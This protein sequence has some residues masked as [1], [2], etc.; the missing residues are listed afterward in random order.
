M[1]SKIATLLRQSI[2]ESYSSKTAISFS[3][4][5]DS[6]VILSILKDQ[7]LGVF[8]L[9]VEGS[10]DLQTSRKV[11]NELGVKLS[12][13]IVDETQILEAYEKVYVLLPMD[14]LSVQILIPVYLVAEAASKAGYKK[15]LFGSGAE[16]LFAGYEKY[17]RAY[18]EG[19]DVESM[20]K[21]EFKTLP[22]RDIAYVK[23]ICKHFGIEAKFPFY[24][25]ELA[26]LMFS[27]PISERLDNRQ[28]KKGILRQASRLLNVP[29]LAIERK[30]QAMQYGSGVHK[31]I[32]RNADFLNKKYPG[33]LG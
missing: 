4:G 30:K 8:S 6:T 5:I 28:I 10:P 20:L 24:N 9:G 21:E 17:Y 16:E 19:R 12:E 25:V 26:N 2:L 33:K 1:F 29:Q 31:V 3:G 27:V 32:L 14:L 13:L 23:R 22:D 18:E 7:P 15:L 11:A